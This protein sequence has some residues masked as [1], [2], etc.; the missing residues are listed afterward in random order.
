VSTPPPSDEDIARQRGI[1]REMIRHEDKLR[2][3]K[4][5]WLLTFNGFLF[6]A[7]GFAWDADERTRLVGVLALLGVAVALSGVAAMKLSSSAVK[8]LREW[9]DDA[10]PGAEWEAPIVGFRLENLTGREVWLRDFQPWELLP[11]FLVSAWPLIFLLS[12]I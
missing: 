12:A 10:H 9:S 11:W 1:I 3:D 4:L 8:R 6:A 7:L 5:G 2:A